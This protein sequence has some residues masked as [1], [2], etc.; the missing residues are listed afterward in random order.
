MKARRV[1]GVIATTVLV[2]GIGVPA[3]LS[4]P[5]RITAALLNVSELPSSLRN[6]ECSSLLSQDTITTCSFDIDPA[7]AKRL[8]VGWPYKPPIELADSSH[9]YGWGLKVGTPFPVSVIY[10][11]STDQGAGPYE[12]VD[13]SLM[14]NAEQ[15][16]GLVTFFGL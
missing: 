14:F 10:E 3:Y 9:Q 8:A 1:F 2:A 13:V 12:Y 15:S 4:R 5:S 6:S 7:D 11:Y 16:R